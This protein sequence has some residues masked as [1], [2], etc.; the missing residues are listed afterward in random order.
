MAFQRTRR[1]G[2]SPVTHSSGVG[3]GD[4]AG[5][6]SSITRGRPV[7]RFI[8]TFAALV[9]LYYVVTSMQWFAGVVFPLSLRLNAHAAGIV[10]NALGEQV[11][12]DGP[13]MTASGVRLEIRRGCDALEPVALYVAAVIAFPIAWRAKLKGALAGVIGLLVLN[14]IRIVS[15]YYIVRAAPDWFGTV[16]DDIWQP[17]FVLCA[18]GIWLAWLLWSTSGAKPD[19]KP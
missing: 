8:C 11:T 9:L 14:Q 16:H 18:M 10:L 17:L 19:I 3:S 13:F 12:I 15:L 1:A 7:L 4:S 5:R 2:L 6:S